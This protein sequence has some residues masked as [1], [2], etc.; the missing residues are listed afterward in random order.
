MGSA[1]VSAKSH[2]CEHVSDPDHIPKESDKDQF[3]VK[4]AFNLTNIY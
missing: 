2:E 3:N 1:A 4:Q